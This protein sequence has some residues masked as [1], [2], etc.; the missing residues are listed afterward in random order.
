M[1][2]TGWDNFCAALEGKFVHDPGMDFVSYDE[3]TDMVSIA[4]DLMVP[5]PV[6]NYARYIRE[7]CSFPIGYNVAELCLRVCVSQNYVALCPD[8]AVEDVS[9]AHLSNLRCT[10]FCHKIVLRYL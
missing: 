8:G 4:E 6:Y 9:V 1:G 10:N 5:V 2:T 3:G 7:V